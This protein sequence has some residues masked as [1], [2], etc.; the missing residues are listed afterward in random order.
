MSFT[1]HH[2]GRAQSNQVDEISHQKRNHEI[3]FCWP[4]STQ[5]LCFELLIEKRSLDA[6]RL[7][8]YHHKEINSA[9]HHVALEK[10]PKLP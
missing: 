3:S 5:E 2:Q 1:N 9:N 8:P 4:I 10:N 6:F 7:F